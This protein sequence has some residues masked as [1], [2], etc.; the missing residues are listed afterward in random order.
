M[1]L[2]WEGLKES[3]VLL[4]SGD[5]EM[6]EIFW[7]S[8]KV[9]ASAMAFGAA[10]GLPLGVFL[11]VSNFRGRQALLSLANASMGLPPTVVGLWVALFLWRSGP[12]G[13]LRLI[14]TPWAIIVAEVIL[15]TPILVALTAAATQAKRENLHEFLMSLGVNRFQYVR[16]LL[17]EIRV[18]LLAAIIAGFGRVFSEVGAAMMVGGNIKGETRTLTTAIVLEVSKGAFDRA[19]ALSF[20]LLAVSLS[21]TA[22]LTH[23][24]QRFG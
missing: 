24:Q 14:Y 3:I 18:S 6:L 2:L 20:I 23:V 4:F 11:G 8:L 21:I 22:L 7:L 15:T 5:R 10:L 19:L 13:D 17:R 9:A 16:L 12:L 1:Q